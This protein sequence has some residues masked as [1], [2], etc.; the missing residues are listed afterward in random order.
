[1]RLLL[2]IGARSWGDEYM[3]T[4]LL[5]GAILVVASGLSAC[6]DKERMGSASSPSEEAAYNAGAARREYDRSVAEYRSCLATNASNASACDGQ[7][8][9]M[10]AN[11][12]ALSASL[13]H[14]R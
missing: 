4:H 9:I 13:Q 8:R 11:E 10:E 7:R 14:P 12:S 3:R 5:V 6:A 2:A 1:M